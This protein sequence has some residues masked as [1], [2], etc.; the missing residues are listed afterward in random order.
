MASQD[1][2]ELVDFGPRSWCAIPFFVLGFRL[3]LEGPFPTRI[4]LVHSNPGAQ[5]RFRAEGA[6]PESSL[7]PS[8]CKGPL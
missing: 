8:F 6:D 2:A 3:P 1:E 4:K 7:I 5:V